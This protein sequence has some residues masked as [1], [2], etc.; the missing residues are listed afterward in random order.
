MW[1]GGEGD[2][3][4][5][6]AL[7]NLIYKQKTPEIKNSLNFLVYCKSDNISFGRDYICSFCEKSLNWFD[8]KCAKTQ[9]EKNPRV[10]HSSLFHSKENRGG[11]W[12]KSSL[13]FLLHGCLTLW[14]TYTAT[15]PPQNPPRPRPQ[16]FI[17]YYKYI[18]WQRVLNDLHI[19]GQAFLW[20]D[21]SAPRP[22]LHPLPFPASNLSLFS[23]SSCVSPVELTDDGRGGMGVGEE[24]NHST[25]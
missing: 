23:Q 9:A 15:L 8:R 22:P 3:P 21:D 4:A 11:V 6:G 20:S 5:N 13:Y 14:H 24:P 10:F 25:A 18:F 2:N 7:Y 16:A 1:G 17:T 12:N 19:E